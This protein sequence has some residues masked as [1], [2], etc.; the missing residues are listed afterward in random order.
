MF[1]GDTIDLCANKKCGESCANT[2]GLLQ[3]VRFCQP[4]GSC[5]TDAAPKCLDGNIEYT[6]RLIK[7]YM[8]LCIAILLSNN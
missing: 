1:K 4:D 5:D 8:T 2:C 3:V 7:S 6:I